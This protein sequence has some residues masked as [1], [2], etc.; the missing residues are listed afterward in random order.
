MSYRT[1]KFCRQLFCLSLF[2]SFSFPSPGELSRPQ[3]KCLCPP[4]YYPGAGNL[5]SESVASDIETL[6]AD[7]LR[8][9]FVGEYDAVRSINYNAYD[10][11]VDRAASHGGM[12]ILGLIDYQS[13][14][15]ENSDEWGTDSFRAKFVQRVEE[16]ITHFHNR[17]NP[18]KHWEIWNEPDLDVPGFDAR[19]EPEPYGQILVETYQAIKAIDPEAVVV[20]GGIS[21]KGFQYT[22]NYL[23]DIYNASS[24]ETFYSINGYYPFDV[25]AVHPYPETFIDPDPIQPGQRGLDDV[26]NDRVKIYMDYYGDGDK[27]VWLTEMGWNSDHVSRQYQANYLKSSYELIDREVPYVERYFWFKYEDFIINPDYPDYWGLVTQ[28]YERK[29][30]WE[31]YRQ[32]TETGTPPPTPTPT[33]TPQPIPGQD[34]PVWDGAN[35]SDLPVQVSSHDLLEG[36]NGIIIGG[37]FHEASVGSVAHLTNGLFDSNGLTLVLLDYA[38]PALRVRYSFEEPV[39]IEEVRVFAGHGADGGSRAF[40]SNDII[41]NGQ[42]AAVEL[43]TG[44]YG[45]ESGG[46]SAVSVVRWLPAAG[47]TYAATRVSE[48]DVLLW[49]T[50]QMGEIFVDRWST[51]YPSDTDGLPKAYVAPIIKEIDVLGRLSPEEEFPGYLRSY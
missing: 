15:S 38:E 42:A 44:F 18:I 41:I 48:M 36:K 21:P 16:I 26:L 17:P 13:V 5:F 30:A 19:I 50:S 35:D 46:D 37:G 20:L 9:E 14:S 31:A 45:Q 3:L 25:V 47:Q 23:Y 2:L 32:L 22:S 34:P 4:G 39:D 33:A 51:D 7:M 10:T 8:I 49:C 12:K 43:N 24:I 40:Q 1:G 27:P 29:P 28:T 11:I 6:G